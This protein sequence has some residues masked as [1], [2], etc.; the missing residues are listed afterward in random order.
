MSNKYVYCVV[1]T[2][3]NMGDK[4]TIAS[5]FNSNNKL[6]LILM[7]N[8]RNSEA[9]TPTP[10]RN[11]V[12]CNDEEKTII[13]RAYLVLGEFVLI[14]TEG[15][16]Q[17]IEL[18]TAD[19][20]ITSI[21]IPGPTA[22]GLFALTI[23]SLIRLRIPENSPNFL[24][25]LGMLI[26][27][28]ADIYKRGSRE[29]VYGWEVDL[30]LAYISTNATKVDNKLKLLKKEEL[31]S[32]CITW[33]QSSY[34][35][36]LRGWTSETFLIGLNLA[37]PWFNP[38]TVARQYT[39]DL[40]ES[41]FKSLFT[42]EHKNCIYDQI[43][44][45]LGEHVT[46]PSI[47]RLEHILEGIEKF[48]PYATTKQRRELT[49]I[50]CKIENK[51]SSLQ[52]ANSYNYSKIINRLYVTHEVSLKKKSHKHLQYSAFHK[53]QREAT[54]QPDEKLLV[55]IND[56]TFKPAEILEIPQRVDE[57][58]CF[59]KKLFPLCH[60]TH[61]KAQHKF[62]FLKLEIS[63]INPNQFN[64]S[65]LFEMIATFFSYSI[66]NWD[67]L[68]TERQFSLV[69]A[70]TTEQCYIF[71]GVFKKHLDSKKSL[72]SRVKNLR[73]KYLFILL[74]LMHSGHLK[75]ERR[76]QD[77]IKNKL[78]SGKYNY[79]TMEFIEAKF[80]D[81]ELKTV[82]ELYNNQY[83]RHVYESDNMDEVLLKV[84][85][86]LSRLQALKL[87]RK[88][89]NSPFLPLTFTIAI[90]QPLINVA[91]KHLEIDRAIFI[92]TDTITK[93]TSNYDEN[94]FNEDLNYALL[95]NTYDATSA[96][97]GL[98]GDA[99]RFEIFERIKLEIL[100][101]DKPEHIEKFNLKVLEILNYFVA[102]LDEGGQEIFD[103][104]TVYSETSYEFFG[105]IYRYKDI[106]F[107]FSTLCAFPN[108]FWTEEIL[109]LKNLL[110]EKLIQHIKSPSFVKPENTELPEGLQEIIY[111]AETICTQ[112]TFEELI[113]S[114]DEIQE[115]QSAFEKAALVIESFNPTQHDC[116]KFTSLLKLL[117]KS[118]IH[119]HMNNSLCIENIEQE[120][121]KQYDNERYQRGFNTHIKPL[122]LTYRFLHQCTNSESLKK[123]FNDVLIE[124][125][126]GPCFRTSFE[127]EKAQ[128]EVDRLIN[129]KDF[130][131]V[132]IN[133]LL[134]M[135]DNLGHHIIST[136]ALYG[137][138]KY[139]GLSQRSL[140]I[141]HE[142]QHQALI[143]QENI[144][145]YEGL[146]THWL[147]LNSQHEVKETGCSV[148]HQ[149]FLE[150]ALTIW[151]YEK[152]DFSI[153]PQDIIIPFRNI[154][155]N[156]YSIAPETKLALV[157]ACQDI[158]STTNFSGINEERWLEMFN[159]FLT[160]SP[161]ENQLNS[162]T[163]QSA[164][165]NSP[166]TFYTETTAE[167]LTIDTIV[168][169]TKKYIVEQFGDTRPSVI[170]GF[171]SK[172]QRG[173]YDRA[174]NLIKFL[175]K[176]KHSS[177]ERKA[178]VLK[179]CEASSDNTGSLKRYILSED[180]I[181]NM[182]GVDRLD[183]AR[184]SG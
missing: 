23:A 31:G 99:E 80:S 88:K 184:P 109:A 137:L 125:H 92:A 110:I 158:I 107:L 61:I 175:D 12:Q 16:K 17:T 49:S 163:S 48:S 100:T 45:S 44:N 161:S 171:F 26:E 104:N 144:G 112:D 148:A 63:A 118:N 173:G 180:S 126:L 34:R 82:F 119:A 145:N 94:S 69:I 122:F 40:T 143:I 182:L 138:I 25:A 54:F 129:D 46:A 132:V 58:P 98:V 30:F 149:A 81:S 19:E 170:G 38:N 5:Q 85:M 75:I 151:L 177:D 72:W 4:Y 178:E 164:V 128:R 2:L 139:A 22:I 96:R 166:F 90:T 11:L 10:L 3:L 123:W 134:N 57:L 106:G 130:F 28:Q 116:H 147:R 66:N 150:Q 97:S 156:R 67:V 101:K 135:F 176:E 55:L 111:A 77:K 65:Q 36:D 1:S 141:A 64:S 183:M 115:D 74:E 108:W 50:V 162:P 179:A 152:N 21:N 103:I 160:I 37:L 140:A 169:Q 154:L 71:D 86:I 93:N 59:W 76:A 15:Q 27:H 153:I 70:L 89:T 159:I 20:L 87:Y 43:L 142:K 105:R 157:G 52:K 113:N 168:S 42:E 13:F 18:P 167:T 6:R 181:V 155:E 35:D 14:D 114:Y 51:Y 73:Y 127:K 174:K 68:A 53:L 120:T 33:L 29:E 32:S 62:D 131:L 8:D 84:N 91:V 9:K 24:I 117:K 172:H 165:V 95:L 136:L 102:I 78:I 79:H 56:N 83:N 121:F 39:H 146:I 41:W 133:G 47:V 7:L 124:I 60:P